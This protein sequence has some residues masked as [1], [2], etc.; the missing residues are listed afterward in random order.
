MAVEYILVNESKKEMISFA[1]L[2]GSKMREL[3]G[4][5]AT[6]SIVTWYLLNNQGD[7]IQFVSDTYEEWPFNS[8]SR[9]L[10][11]SYPDKTNEIIDTLIES[12]ILQDNAILHVDEDEP[13]TVY[14]RDVVN[15]WCK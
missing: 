2:N 14:T 5:A 6:S 10:A 9:E 8:G 13:N 7:Q 4:N 3:V 12:G 1:H 11:W 15:V